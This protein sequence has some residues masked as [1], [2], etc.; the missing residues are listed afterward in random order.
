M[1]N[2]NNI[3]IGVPFILEVIEYW[4]EKGKTGAFILGHDLSQN[5]LK[6]L[7]NMKIITK[8]IPDANK[9]H[10][11][12]YVIYYDMDQYKKW[13]CARKFGETYDDFC[14]NN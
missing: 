11:T 7:D 3:I 13:S 9:N 14:K 12:F 8:E 4:K 1:I 10:E 2:F 6:E 5:I